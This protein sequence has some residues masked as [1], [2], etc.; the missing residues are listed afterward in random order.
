MSDISRQNQIMEILNAEKSV[1]VSKL[2]KRLYVSPATIRRDLEAMAKKGLLKRV[3]GG[4]ILFASKNEESSIITRSKTMVQEKRVIAA[5]AVNFLKN[6]QSVFLDSSSTVCALVPLLN[7]FKYLTII[8]N[9]LST[10]I[11][12]G[13]KTDFKIFVPSGFVK[14]PSNS[15]LGDGTNQALAD[16]HCDLFIFSAAGLDTRRGITE[17]SIEQAEAKKIMMQNAEKRILLLD[18]SKFG[19]SYLAKSCDLANVDVLVTDQKPSEEYMRFLSR[20]PNL[21][22]VY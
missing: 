14:R 2:M 12:V 5:N 8:T 21:K 13:E 1:T 18:H 22:I 17:A 15:L 11:E 7:D 10:A 4:A 19:Q 9:A 6:N 16:L 3:H 20:Y